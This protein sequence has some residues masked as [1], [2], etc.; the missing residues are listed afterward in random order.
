MNKDAKIIKINKPEIVALKS[1]I[2]EIKN[3]L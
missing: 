1:K 2:T 3:L